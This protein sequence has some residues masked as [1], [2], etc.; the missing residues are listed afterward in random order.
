MVPKQTEADIGYIKDLVRKADREPTP[1]SLYYL[2]AAIVLVGY[3]LVDF[4]PR[5]V[6]FF[7]MLAG[8]LGGIASGILA[9]RADLHRGQLS[10][11]IGIRHALHWGGMLV[12]TALAV[13]LPATHRI[14]GEETGTVIQ[15]IV[16]LGWW[17]A[18]VHFDRVFLWIGGLMMLGFVGIIFL[19]SYA[20]T[21]LGVLMAIALTI[22]ALRG[23]RRHAS[24]TS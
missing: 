20:W 23:G 15:L 4:A 11:E 18:G 13:L 7:W 8:P 22:V 17:T 12:L 19:P 1:A 3:S 2:W 24:K 9:Y 14:P 6:G 10:R 16:T 5:Y 21:A